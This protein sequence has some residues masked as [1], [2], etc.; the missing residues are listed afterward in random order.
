MQSG[1]ITPARD[2][3]RRGVRWSCAL[4]WHVFALAL[5]WLGPGDVE[6]ERCEGKDS[7]PVILGRHVVRS[8][9]Q[10]R[11][12]LCALPMPGRHARVLLQ[13]S[14]QSPDHGLTLASSDGVTRQPNRL[15]LADQLRVWTPRVCASG[16][17]TCLDRPNLGL[18]GA[19]TLKPEALVH[20]SGVRPA[21]MACWQGA[22]T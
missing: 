6:A 1:P 2:N 18:A 19:T 17:W 12:P 16:C 20:L 14:P 9:T 22:R 11:P 4:P 3:C 15:V 5:G 10:G 7:Q 8:G 13:V 21:G